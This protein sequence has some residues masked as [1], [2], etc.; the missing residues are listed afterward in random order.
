MGEQTG[1]LA[2]RAGIDD[3]V[4]VWAAGIIRGIDEIQNVAR[5]LFR[6]GHGKIGSDQMGEIVAGT[7][8]F[9]QF[10]APY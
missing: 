2:T 9:S 4:A 6:F 5:E 1:E 7:P 8:S 3:A 10:A